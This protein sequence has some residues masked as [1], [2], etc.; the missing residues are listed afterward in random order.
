MYIKVLLQPIILACL[1][2]G[3]TAALSNKGNIRVRSSRNPM[4]PP[5]PFCV[6]VVF[7]VQNSC[8]IADVLL[9]AVNHSII[10]L[11]DMLKSEGQTK[12]ALLTYS[13]KA[14]E[15]IPLKSAS[16]FL[17][18]YSKIDLRGL[19]KK[20]AACKNIIQ[21]NTTDALAMID[22]NMEKYF[23]VTNTFSISRGKLIVLYTDGVTFTS[24][25]TIGE[26]QPHVKEKIDSLQ[27]KGVIFAPIDYDIYFSKPNEVE[28]KTEFHL[29]TQTLAKRE[30]H[31]IDYFINQFMNSVFKRYHCA[32]L[33]A[34]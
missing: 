27:S 2:A 13:A 10:I 17:R 25:F 11:A 16:E 33:N 30:F 31:I 22:N 20:S 34:V 29:Y 12:I 18:D 6:D 5:G 28:K 32:D 15:L 9:D 8:T 3:L 26:E 23:P 1:L 4:S 19:P 24:K 21:A 7:I 14:K